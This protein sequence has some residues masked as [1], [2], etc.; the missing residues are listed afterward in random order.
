MTDILVEKNPSHINEAEMAA[1]INDLLDLGYHSES[2]EQSNILKAAW[3]VL[4]I[5]WV[6]EDLPHL[7]FDSTLTVLGRRIWKRYRGRGQIG[8]KR[9]DVVDADDFTIASHEI[10]FDEVDD[11]D[12]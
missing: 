3:W 5:H 4:V 10:E 6:G 11:D 1:I 12:G 9:I 8:P 2:T 7:G